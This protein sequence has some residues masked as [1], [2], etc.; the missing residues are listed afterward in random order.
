[1]S[2]AVRTSP[3]PSSSITPSS[4]SAGARQTDLGCLALRRAPLQLAD[5]ALR[6]PPDATRI[7]P[8]V[9]FRVGKREL[10]RQ[11]DHLG[12]IAAGRMWV[13]NHDGVG[14]DVIREA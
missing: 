12:T 8:L 14:V 6:H 3:V 11:R 7:G 10:L 1:M 5:A 13:G 9:G 2:T 4:G